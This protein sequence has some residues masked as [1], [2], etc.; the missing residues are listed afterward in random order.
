MWMYIVFKEVQKCVCQITETFKVQCPEYDFVTQ[1][2]LKSKCHVTRRRLLVTEVNWLRV[3]GHSKTFEEYFLNSLFFIVFFQFE[4]GGSIRPKWCH[5]HVLH[6]PPGQFASCREEISSVH[7]DWWLR[8][9]VCSC[10]PNLILL[11]SVLS[12]HTLSPQCHHGD[13]PT[14]SSSTCLCVCASGCLFAPQCRKSHYFRLQYS[15]CQC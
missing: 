2:S 10:I 13:P 5:R 1:F 4:R 12:I 3:I 11:L 8:V 6:S 15:L 14:W 7:T 9:R